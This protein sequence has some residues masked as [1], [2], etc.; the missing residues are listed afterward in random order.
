MR[1]LLLLCVLVAVAVA[2]V[3]EIERNRPAYVKAV[4]EE[5]KLKQQLR[6]LQLQITR[7]KEEVRLMKEDSFQLEKYAREK[8]GYAGSNEIIFK[9]DQ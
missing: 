4:N 9:F 3:L 2:V 8:F 6:D 7:L 5:R 1:Y